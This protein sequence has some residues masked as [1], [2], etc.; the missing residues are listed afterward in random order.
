LDPEFEFNIRRCRTPEE[1][2]AICRAHLDSDEPLPPTP[3]AH[4]KLFSG[5]TGLL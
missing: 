3:P 5:F 4:S 1:F 2:W